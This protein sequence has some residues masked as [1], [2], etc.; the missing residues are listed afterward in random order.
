MSAYVPDLGLLVR[1]SALWTA[2]IRRLGY[3]NGYTAG[4]RSAGAPA[5]RA[6]DSLG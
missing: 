3:R 5:G 4:S 2:G 6:A 1:S